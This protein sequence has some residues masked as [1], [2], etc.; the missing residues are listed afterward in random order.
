MPNTDLDYSIYTVADLRARVREYYPNAVPVGLS[1]MR[2]ADV[3]AVLVEQ[4]DLFNEQIGARNKTKRV[5]HEL[6][7][8][9]YEEKT[10]LPV[11]PVKAKKRRST[12][13][14]QKQRRPR[15]GGS[16]VS[17]RF[18]TKSR[19]NRA[20]PGNIHYKPSKNKVN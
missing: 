17:R 16:R 10:D 20:T 15:G 1:K 19:A 8:E 7:A 4:R 5:A 6:T 11:V 18:G 14:P 2:K 9:Q 13:K 12:P 3:I